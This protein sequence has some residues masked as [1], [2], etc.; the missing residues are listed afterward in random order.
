MAREEEEENLQGWPGT[1][2]SFWEV[3]RQTGWRGFMSFTCSVKI[4]GCKL[5]HKR[6][7]P[8]ACSFQVTRVH[9]KFWPLVRGWGFLRG[10]VVQNLPA[11]AGDK[12]L[13]WVRKIDPREEEMATHSRILAW[14]ILWTEKP[15]GYSP[16]NHRVRRDW[17]HRDIQ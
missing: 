3:A 15:G 2:S 12:D 17:A 8:E 9:C 11:N 6:K 7:K 13:V 10:A 4:E 14:K 1:Q 16:W 5:R